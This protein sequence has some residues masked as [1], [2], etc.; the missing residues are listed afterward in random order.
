MEWESLYTL[1]K[2]KKQE[3]E[4]NEELDLAYRLLMQLNI[5]SAMIMIRYDI[6]SEK[7]ASHLKQLLQKDT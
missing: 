1:L 6:R 7:L 3:Y 2:I 4:N 5:D